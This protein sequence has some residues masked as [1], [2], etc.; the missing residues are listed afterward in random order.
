VNIL[1]EVPENWKDVKRLSYKTSIYNTVCLDLNS[2]E[3][4]WVKERMGETLIEFNVFQIERVQNLVAYNRYIKEKLILE[5]KYYE[6]EMQIEKFL[7]HGTKNTNPVQLI[8]AEEGFDMRFSN[9]GMWGCGIYF[10]ENA[11]YSDKYAHKLDPPYQD[12]K[13]IFLSKVLVGKQFESLANR[14]LKLPPI[15]EETKQ[16]YDSVI[17]N[18]LN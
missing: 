16:R 5:H 13:Q 10:A 7:F 8:E 15:N 4:K 18:T 11:S 17:G 12:I 9:Q 2:P 14:S 6:E 1:S 3:A